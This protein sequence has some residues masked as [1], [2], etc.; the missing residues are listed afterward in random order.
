MPK[1][2]LIIFLLVIFAG[3]GYFLASSGPTNKSSS[4]L[5]FFF[6]QQSPSPTPSPFD[7]NLKSEF[8]NPS[9]SPT[10]SPS[11][12]SSN[13][14]SNSSAPMGED[15]A[16]MFGVVDAITSS[17][18][19]NDFSKLK[20]YMDDL[21]DVTLYATECCGAY[22]QE[23]AIEFIQGKVSASTPWTLNEQDPVILRIKSLAEFRDK[24]VALSTHGPVLVFKITDN[25]LQA[26]TYYS[27]YQLITNGP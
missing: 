15:P 26:V 7:V 20:A 21:V 14:S 27:N 25:K 1:I 18:N 4:P 17:F 16:T 13:S 2:L 5:S 10:P 22:S 19:T 8:A 24:T 6:N 12:K 3:A 9:L 23:K 11:P